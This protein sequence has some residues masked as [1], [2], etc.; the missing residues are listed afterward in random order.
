ML[1]EMMAVLSE[2]EMVGLTGKLWADC[3]AEKKALQTAGKLGSTTAE[4]MVEEMVDRRDLLKAE[5]WV[6]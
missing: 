5:K 4:Q 6:D 2:I 1:V 3:S